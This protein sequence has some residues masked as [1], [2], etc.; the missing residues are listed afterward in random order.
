VVGYFAVV[1]AWGC[2]RGL[3]GK[4]NTVAG[5]WFSGRAQVG[6]GSSA[7]FRPCLA[8]GRRPAP[9]GH[10]PALL[11]GVGVWALCLGCGVGSGG[12]LVVAWSVGQVGRVGVWLVGAAGAVGR[13]AKRKRRH[14]SAGRPSG[15]RS[16][17]A[18]R[19]GLVGRAVIGGPPPQGAAVGSSSSLS[20]NSKKSS[21]PA[22]LGRRWS[23]RRGVWDYKKFA[24]RPRNG[25]LARPQ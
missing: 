8:L 15:V 5:L 9:L 22:P 23:R 24:L 7:V 4:T 16:S 6:A 12:C 17:G 19:S 3:A 11:C 10:S 13:S 20:L 2:L 1:F 21:P 18:G 14:W 25:Q